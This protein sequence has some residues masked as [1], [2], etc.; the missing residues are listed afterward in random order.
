MAVPTV[1]E[2]EKNLKIKNTNIING[3]PS[4]P[5]PVPSWIE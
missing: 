1:L 2:K 3:L 4:S 5:I